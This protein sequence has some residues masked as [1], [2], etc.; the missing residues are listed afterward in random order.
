M[1]PGVWSTVVGV[2]GSVRDRGVRE[3]PTELVYYPLV[4]MSGERTFAI[5]T[6]QYVVRGS[7][8]PEAAAAIARSA[9]RAIDPRLPVADLRTVE[10]IVSGATVRTSFAMSTLSLS[11]IVALLLASVGIYAVVSQA[12]SRR[13]REI[14]VRIALGA[15]VGDVRRLVVRQ[16]AV[17]GA[18]GLCIGLGASVAL[19]RFARTLLFEVSPT[20]PVTLVLVSVL[21]LGFVLL[22]SYLPARRASAIDPLDAIRSE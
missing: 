19:T 11:A 18:I 4:G 10:T 22:A 15:R 21:L 5:R 7:G 16:G 3:P 20:D 2:V 12:V 17:L 1:P 13:N 14:G 8:A 6:M 9:V